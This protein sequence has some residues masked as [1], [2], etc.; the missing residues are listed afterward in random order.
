MP[1]SSNSRKERKDGQ[2][3]IRIKKAER[4]AFIDLCDVLDTSAA[5]EIRR[6]I[7]DFILYHTGPANDIGGPDLTADEQP[8]RGPAKKIKRSKKK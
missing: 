8:E 4:D 2:L 5:R 3:V 1:D 6:F 7:R